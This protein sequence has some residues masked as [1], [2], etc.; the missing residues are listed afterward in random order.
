V[1]SRKIPRKALLIV[2]TVVFGVGLYL[3]L[4]GDKA[5]PEYKTEVVK[6]GDVMESVSATG[7]V[8]PVVSVSVGTQVSGTIKKINVDYNDIVKKGQVLIDLDREVYESRVVEAESELMAKRAQMA[9]AEAEL[10]KQESEFQRIDGLFEKGFIS[11]NEYETAE[12]GMKASRASLELARAELKRSKATLEEARE[13]LR[14]TI[15]KSPLD[16][17][18][19]TRD[20]E[21]GQT[22]SASLQAPTLLT[23]GDLKKMQIQASV[24]EADI[25]KVRVGQNALFYVDSF[26]DKEFQAEVS[27]I[28]YSPTIEQNVVTYDVLMY[29]DNDN[30]LLR[31]GMT[32]N[33]VIIIMEKKD[34]ILVPNNALRVRFPNKSKSRAKT[35]GPSV[36]VIEGGRPVMRQVKLGMGDEDA[37]EVTKGL[38][39]GDTVVVESGNGERDRRRGFGWFH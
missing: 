16:G 20:V 5:E 15:I 26:P 11:K 23:V 9:K 24:D 17:I 14:K 19:I 29:F 25:G 39:E 13:N 12:Y 27:K 22:V 28:Y 21:E 33:I 7:R 1:R 36:W 32:A 38:K 10:T 31:P 30:L 18:V 37:T 3:M 2:F 8:N 34:V 4:Q 6:R 35:D